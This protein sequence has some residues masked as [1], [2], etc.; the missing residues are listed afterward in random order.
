M[1][2]ILH[3]FKGLIGAFCII[4]IFNF[5]SCSPPTP[6]TIDENSIQEFHMKSGNGNERLNSGVN[7]YIDYSTCMVEAVRSSAFFAQIRPRITGMNPVLYGIKGNNINKITSDNVTVNVELNNINE[8]PYANL[9]RA[10]EQI[11]SGNNQAIMITD[12]EYWTEGIGEMTDL[13]FFKDA[14]II[15]LSRGFDIYVF[16]EDYRE[17]YRSV[18]YDKKRFYFIFTDDNLQNNI[19]EGLNS[20]FDFSQYSSSVRLVKLSLNDIQIRGKLSFYSEL[21]STLIT[22]RGFTAFEI[23]SDWNNMDTYILN[24]TNSDDGT[25]IEGGNYLLRGLQMTSDM[26]SAYSY[27]DLDIKVYNVSSSFLYNEKPDLPK[28]EI[29]DVFVFDKELYKKTGE[30]G[31]KMSKDYYNYNSLRDTS[32]NLLRI[33]I[34]AEV[35]NKRLNESDFEWRSLSSRGLNRSVYE[36]IF[37]TII[38]PLIDPSLNKKGLYTIYLKTDALK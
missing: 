25:V 4:L 29:K 18:S 11:C 34:V 23:E 16:V 15:W 19:Y 5:E 35:T 27:P 3:K 17:E 24:A 20:A 1:R 31:I 12:G 22:D 10:S 6:I 7:L 26:L 2:F 28:C 37:Q 32:Q 30:I 8:F 21:E 9:K 14:F 36:S 38:D 33:D 13:P